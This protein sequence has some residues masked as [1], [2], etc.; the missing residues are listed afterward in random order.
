MA[1]DKNSP[2]NSK[3]DNTPVIL[4]EYAALRSE[5]LKRIEF[6]YQ[7][8]NLTIIFAGTFL[9]IGVQPNMPAYI[10]L[11][12]PILAL[13]LLAGWAHNS[14]TIVGISKYINENLQPKLRDLQWEG[15]ARKH[16]VSFYGTLS[17]SGLV[18]TTQ[19]LAIGLSLPKFSVND[20]TQTVLLVISIIAILFTVVLL[21]GVSGIWIT[22]E[23]KK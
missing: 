12:Y 5:M 16:H 1:Q 13:F 21:R 18:L 14:Q 10:L 9:S 15:F 20:V 2:L 23:R 3:P 22:R 6:R 19:I 7:L 11:V 4:A 17:T 8:L